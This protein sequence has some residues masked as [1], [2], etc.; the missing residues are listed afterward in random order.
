MPLPTSKSPADPRIWLTLLALSFSATCQRFE[1]PDRISFA[2]AVTPGFVLDQIREMTGLA[3]LT[4]GPAETSS[5]DGYTFVSPVDAMSYVVTIDFPPHD[6]SAWAEEASQGPDEA[7]SS[8]LDDSCMKS[9]RRL[10]FSA[11][12]GGSFRG[13]E[14]I[15]SDSRYDVKI[16]VF[17]KLSSAQSSQ[18]LELERLAAVLSKKYCSATGNKAVTSGS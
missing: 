7:L 18:P 16:G 3:T 1:N 9:F 4:T 15:T 17:E 6:P 5:A 12:T 13:V 11:G 14:F 8:F 2:D 10:P